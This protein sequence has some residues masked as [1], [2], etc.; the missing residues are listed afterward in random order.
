MSVPSSIDTL[1]ETEEALLDYKNMPSTTFLVDSETNQVIK[2]IDDIEALKQTF[3]FIIETPQNKTPIFSK[4]YGMDWTDLIGQNEDY[5][6]SEVVYRL[7]DAVIEDDRFNSVELN[8]D[9]PFEID[10]DI[11]TI[12]VD[13]D[14]K[15]GL[16]TTTV[17]IEK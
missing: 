7:N 12:Y 5:I 6:I 4:D 16:F 11:I 17:N 14:T 2:M 10:G 1:A 3:K 15:Y 9:N 8:S 13:I